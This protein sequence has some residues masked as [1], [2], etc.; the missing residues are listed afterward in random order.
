MEMNSAPHDY[1]YTP[2]DAEAV[3][4]PLANAWR[5]KVLTV[6]RRGDHSLTELGRAVELRT[7]HLQFHLRALVDAGFVMLDRRKHR[8]SI[9]A[10]GMTALTCAE[11]LVSRLGP[12]PGESECKGEGQVMDGGADD[13]R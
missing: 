2:E 1:E 13:D 4:D 5:I 12:M 7:G 11:D 8:Y 3:L 10:R 9:T 6:L